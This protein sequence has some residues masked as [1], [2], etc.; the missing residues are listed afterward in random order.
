MPYQPTVRFAVI[1]LNH[2]HIYPLVKT[3]RAAGGN[4]VAFFAPE[5]DL[6]SAFSSEH[7]GAARVDRM[8]HILEDDSIQLVV[9]AAIPDER[10]GIGLQAMHHGKDFLTDK[11][12]FTTLDQIAEAQRAHAETGQLFYV[13]Y[14]RLSS[15][16]MHRAGELVRTGAIGRPV[17]T[18]GLGPHRINAPTRPPWFY[19]RARYGGIITDLGS[20]LVEQFLFFTG[21]TTADVVS[22]QVA[23]YNHA[24][25]PELEDFGDAVLRGDNGSSGYLRV[26][27]FTPDGLSSFGDQRLTVLGTDGY[28]EVR[29]TCD[30]A[31]R[32]NGEHLFLVDH[33]SVQY[34]D[35]HDVDPQFGRRLL[36]DITHRTQTVMSQ[37][38]CFEAST[39]ALRA[40]ETAHLITSN[41]RAHQN[42]AWAAEST[43][44]YNTQG[45]DV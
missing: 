15:R 19:Q 41:H 7:Q 24:H 23:N 30:L 29:G 32:P 34:I 31:G 6:A 21:A 25:Y 26:D 36:E 44:G 12:G 42:P 11:P 14:G 35:C 18:I 9:S 27:W 37:R 40:E 4:L 38:H 10:A 39:L 13:G 2:N 3:L 17:Q 8:A 22:A 20:H 5:D 16:A 33:Q 43:S 28:L 45:K 1:G